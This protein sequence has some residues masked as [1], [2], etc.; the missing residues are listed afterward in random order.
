MLITNNGESFYNSRAFK[1]SNGRED[2]LDINDLDL[3]GG[4]GGITK[5]PEQLEADRLEAEK[6]KALESIPDIIKDVT[7]E[8]I[9]SLDRNKLTEILE[10]HKG[11]GFDKDGNLIDAE[12]KVLKSPEDIKSELDNLTTPLDTVEEVTIQDDSGKDVVYKLDANKNAIDANGNIVK[13]KKELLELLEESD[14]TG[15]DYIKYISSVTGFQAMDDKGNPVEFENTVEGLAAREIYIVKQEAVKLAK[16]ELDSFFNKNQDILEMME[17]K[18]LHGSLK[19][20][21]T[22]EDFSKIILEDSNDDQHRSIIIKAELARGNSEAR[23]NKIADLLMEDGKGKEEAQ[24]SLKYLI[25]KQTADNAAIAKKL[26]DDKRTELD[27]KSVEFSEVAKVVKSGEAKGYTI[28]E[29]FKVKLAN[30]TQ[31]TMHRNAIYQLITEP[32]SDDG[33][34]RYDRMRAN[35][36]IE[37]KVLDAYVRLTGFDIDTLVNQKVNNKKVLDLKSAKKKFASSKISFS[38]GSGS[39]AAS[40]IKW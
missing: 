11:S 24:A 26:E 29:F 1:S 38:K 19:A 23:A 14:D 5:T 4:G 37:D 10:L 30:G 2:P 39:V 31:T 16:Q 9:K 12:G 8:Y 15:D 35:D 21:A 32:I 20:Y 6:K 3:S 17:Y 25:D 36:S 33:S 22:H 40:D 28:P 34:S 27:K 7:N 18:K 13:T